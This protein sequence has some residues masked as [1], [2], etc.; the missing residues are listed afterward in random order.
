[1][2]ISPGVYTKIVPLESYV[3]EVPSSTALVVFLADKGPS[4]QL[5][6]ISSLKQLDETFGKPN[7]TRYGK[8]SHGHYVARNFCSVS[9]SLYVVRPLPSD[10]KYSYVAV[11]KLK[12]NISNTY[13][14]IILTDGVTVNE[15]S[16]TISDLNNINY[17]PPVLV[18]D[19]STIKEIAVNNSG[20]VEFKTVSTPFVG[21]GIANEQYA[22][23]PNNGKWYSV[24][25]DGTVTALSSSA[26]RTEILGDDGN[27]YVLTYDSS[28]NQL[29]ATPI[30][31][32]SVSSLTSHYSAEVLYAFRGKYQGEWYNNLAISIDTYANRTDYVILNEYQN[33]N[34]TDIIV[35]QYNISFNPSA[36][37]ESGN[38][39]FIKDILDVYSNDLFV[40]MDETTYDANTNSDVTL[41]SSMITPV[42]SIPSSRVNNII[43]QVK[44][45][46]WNPNDLA[47]YPDGTSVLVGNRAGGS[48]S[49]K[50]GYVGH[51]SGTNL[52]D[53]TQLLFGDIV[54]VEEDDKWYIHTEDGLLYEY[55]PYL[56]TA[57]M[58][59][60][61]KTKLANGSDGSLFTSTGLDSSKANE[62]LKQTF[63]GTLVSDVINTEFYWFD[64]ILDGGYDKEVKDSI[65]K[66]ASEIRRD[67]IAIIDNGDNKSASDALK[68]RQDKYYYNSEY[69][70][71]YEPY[72]QINDP[73]SAG[74]KIWITPVYSV[75][76]LIALNDKVN[77]VWYAVAGF[78]RGT[79]AE[80]IDMRYTPTQAERD[81]FYLNQINP[82]VK[83]REG[84]VLFGQLT[85]R[86]KADALQNINIM[87][88]VLYVKRALEQY[89]RYEIFDFED[90]ETFNTI[91]EAFE[92]FLKN[93][94]DRRGLYDF[95]VE[96]TATE[97]QIRNKSA[98]ANIMLHPTRALEKLYLN[99]Y[100]K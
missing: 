56:Y 17:R 54:Y 43:T 26:R 41:F 89:A 95:S 38:T 22:F 36:K 10:A 61:D 81:Q 70:A 13:R 42:G 23:D 1:M 25:G 21:F 40:T 88:L 73:M 44:A 15:D 53:T 52:T 97:Q 47:Q 29:T 79:D 24:A 74:K 93:I 75:A 34:N 100:L 72:I 86:R 90:D 85:S 8:Y 6:F 96:V 84:N 51:K 62:I 67:C 58:L 14:Y 11:V 71:I 57:L 18:K 83:F 31:D 3:E 60:S 55:D 78:E 27:V 99:F 37:D 46:V 50:Q 9:P 59:L 12:E 66:L 49:S 76:K 80:I 16:A 77:D 32:T 65:V 48:L 91:K 28:T 39:I 30:S 2:A 35:G 19:G 68:A 94:Q 82:F 33:Q 20:D 92:L 98:T 7:L 63:D 87:R 64:I 4:N 45:I 5:V 69:V